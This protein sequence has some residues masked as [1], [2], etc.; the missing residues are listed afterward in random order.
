MFD[1]ARKTTSIFISKEFLIFLLTGGLAATANFFSRIIMSY[2]GI[3]F[4]L[5]VFFAYVLGMV[6]AYIL[7]RS[8]VFKKNDIS[9]KRSIALFC[10][11]NLI[12]IVLTFLLSN[13]LYYVLLKDLPLLR[14]EISHGIG[15]ML[16]AVSSYIGHKYFTFR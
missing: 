10:I 14:G 2:L 7:F 1:I 6:V 5:A 13:F 15:I 16:P 8:V 4:Y 12:G 3:E 9:L 11:V